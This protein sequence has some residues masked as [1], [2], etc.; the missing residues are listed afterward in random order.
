MGMDGN[1]LA[2]SPAMAMQLIA[3][4]LVFWPRRGASPAR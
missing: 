2:F 4:I 3:L 1:V